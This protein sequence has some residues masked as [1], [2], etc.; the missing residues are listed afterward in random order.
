MKVRLAFTFDVD[1]HDWYQEF[2]VGEDTAADQ[3]E[4]VRR[5]FVTHVLNAPAVLDLEIGVEHR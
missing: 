1:Q 5:Y 2:G 4:D 3:R